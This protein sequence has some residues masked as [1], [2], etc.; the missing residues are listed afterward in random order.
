MWQKGQWHGKV[1]NTHLSRENDRREQRMS[2]GRVYI[3]RQNLWGR[4]VGRYQHL[5]VSP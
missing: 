1:M 3:H 5:A 2:T 4:D